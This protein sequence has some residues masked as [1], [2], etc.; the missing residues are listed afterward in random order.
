MLTQKSVDFLRENA[1]RNDKE[2]F[3][4]HKKE[5]DALITEPL[6]DLVM[7]L[8]DDMEKIDG[9]IVT[10]P[11][12]GQ[13]ISR[14]YRDT[15]FSSNKALYRDH[16]WVSFRRSKKAFPHYPEFYF[17]FGEGGL[18]SGMGY[19]CAEARLMDCMREAALR[20]DDRFLRAFDEVNAQS[21]FTISGDMYKR[22]RYPDEPENIR[23]WLDRK[24]ICFTKSSSDLSPI[25]SSSYADTLAED[26]SKLVETYRFLIYCE[27]L[28]NDKFSE[29]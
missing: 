5:Y 26:F 17:G 3:H 11:K 24:N 22:S 1:M 12:V 28:K 20:R 7:C 21:T 16:V 19:Y 4:S 15:R 2:W 14:I 29:M 23:L 27:G 25:F 6:R 13:T 10:A 18:F 9:F 8:A